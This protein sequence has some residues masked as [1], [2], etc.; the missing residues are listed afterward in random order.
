GRAPS[1]PKRDI[2][3]S[4]KRAAA[5]RQTMS[6]EKKP[7]SEPITSIIAHQATSQGISPN[8]SPVQRPSPSPND[9]GGAMVAA[10]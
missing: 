6:L 1:R 7:M 3:A 8:T 4:D 9:T 5:T 2:D 10:A